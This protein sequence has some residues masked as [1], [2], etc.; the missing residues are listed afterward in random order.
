MPTAQTTQL[1]PVFSVRSLL[2]LPLFSGLVAGAAL[3]GGL[4]QRRGQGLWYRVQ[5]KP[6]FNPPDWVFPPVWTALYGLIA[7]SGWR[8]FRRPAS[9]RRTV[10]LGLWGT[11]LA[12]N[13][14]WTPLFFGA[15]KK[16]AAL[17]DV[18]LLVGS[19]GAYMVAARKVDRPAAWMLTPYLA[20]TGF[21]AVLNEE[22][23]RRNR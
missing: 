21:A 11:Q 8:V 19:V 1:A 15:H 18:G 17:L 5:R 9:L 4:A 13:A 7:L 22:L 3:L 6:W 12:L 16:G 20:W 23:W 2:G 10:T 14:A